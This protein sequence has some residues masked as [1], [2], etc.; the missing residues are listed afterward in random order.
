[1]H[2]GIENDI[3]IWAPTAPEPQVERKTLIQLLYHTH[4]VACAA[5]VPR[6][7][8]RRQQVLVCDGFT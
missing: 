4:Q 2:A 5:A 7:A 1:M 8:Q 6:H 3:K